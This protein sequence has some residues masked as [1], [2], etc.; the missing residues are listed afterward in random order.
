MSTNRDRIRC[1]KCMEYDHFAKDCLNI[2]DT[3]KEKSQQ[4]QQMVN[5]EEDK[6]VLKVFSSRHL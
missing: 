4:I 6:T 2:S 3:E 5:L 1:F